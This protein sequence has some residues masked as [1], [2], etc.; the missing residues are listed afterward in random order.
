MAIATGNP[1]GQGS[2]GSDLKWWPTGRRLDI[3]ATQNHPWKLQELLAAY[4]TRL[5][6]AHFIT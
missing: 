5:P 4:I 3:L 2:V 1:V 6:V